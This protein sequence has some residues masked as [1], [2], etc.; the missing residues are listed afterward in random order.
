M[1]GYF[2]YF[3]EGVEISRNWTT[4]H[5]LVFWHC[6][7]TVMAPLDV[8][9][10]LLIEDQGLIRVDLFASLG[11]IWFSSVY[12]VSLGCHSFKS[13]ALLLSLLLQL[14][15]YTL[16][17]SGLYVLSFGFC[18]AVQTIAQICSDW[19]APRGQNGFC[20]LTSLGSHFPFSFD[21]I[22]PSFLTSFAY[23]DS[24]NILSRCFGSFQ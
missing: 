10:S 3:W 15:L 8:S 4:T 5:S 24:E 7:G 17:G 9:F 21:Q 16:D 13:C 20:S 11:P 6:L 23:D 2:S 19:S 12:V 18:R 1:G 22:T 14:R